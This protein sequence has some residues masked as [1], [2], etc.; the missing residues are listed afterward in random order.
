MQHSNIE[1]I[2]NIAQRIAIKAMIGQTIFKNLK[3][4]LYMNKF[5]D[6]QHEVCISSVKSKD[7][8]LL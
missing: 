4:K 3:E 1:I 7:R 6:H 8:H 5:A 2:L